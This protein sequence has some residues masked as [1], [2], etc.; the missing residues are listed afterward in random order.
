MD[1]KNLMSQTLQLVNRTT[2]PN[3]LAQLSEEASDIQE[4]SEE[5]LSQ[6]WGGEKPKPPLTFPGRPPNSTDRHGR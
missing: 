2:S 4:L 6:V 1:K 3:L 5:V